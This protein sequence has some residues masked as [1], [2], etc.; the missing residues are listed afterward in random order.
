MQRS[1]DAVLLETPTS[2][3]RPVKV[4]AKTALP[5]SFT[6]RQSNYADHLSVAD[7]QIQYLNMDTIKEEIARNDSKYAHSILIPNSATTLSDNYANKNALGL[8][9]R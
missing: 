4:S 7:E 9:R 2:N 8:V 5:G 6:D 1:Q 3:M